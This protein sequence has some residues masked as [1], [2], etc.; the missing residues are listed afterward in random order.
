MEVEETSNPLEKKLTILKEFLAVTESLKVRCDLEEWEAVARLINRRQELIQVMH[1]IDGQIRENGWELNCRKEIQTLQE[2]QE[3][4]REIKGLDGQCFH[5]ISHFHER[6]KEEL[7]EVRNGLR[8]IHGYIR[9]SILQPR[10]LD[11]RR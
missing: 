5:Q 1:Q 2:I 3:I 4:L 11:L 10:F 9:R 8:T 6:I 7:Y